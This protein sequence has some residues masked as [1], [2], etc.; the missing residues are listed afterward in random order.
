MI[1]QSGNHFPR[2]LKGAMRCALGFDCILGHLY[3]MPRIDFDP[4]LNHGPLEKGTPKSLDMLYGVLAPACWLSSGGIEFPYAARIP[5]RFV[6]EV[7]LQVLSPNLFVPAYSGGFLSR[8]A[9]ELYDFF[10]V[11]QVTAFPE[12][13]DGHVLLPPM[14]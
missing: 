2:F 5:A 4:L 8:L 6:C 3:G 13:S 14:R 1:Y 10:A 12:F 7:R 9:R 11:R